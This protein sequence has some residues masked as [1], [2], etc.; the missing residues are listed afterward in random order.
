MAQR[1]DATKYEQA[2]DHQKE[3]GRKLIEELSLSGRES[4]FDLGCG[5]GGLTAQPAALVP[6]GGLTSQASCRLWNTW[7]FGDKGR[8]RSSV[9]ERMIASTRQANG[10]C[11]ETFHRINVFAKEGVK[12]GVKVNQRGEAR[13]VSA[14]RCY[15]RWPRRSKTRR[16]GQRAKRRPTVRFWDW[17]CLAIC[18]F[19]RARLPKKTPAG[20]IGHRGQHT[21]R[22]RPNPAGARVDVE[23]ANNKSLTR[24]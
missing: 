23:K 24:P 8:F 2:S 1:F 6:R 9:I 11:F 5:D 19:Q 12:G 4:I 22:E 20:A 15:R 10:S 3:W 7:V 13:R 16:P 14:T 21:P 17:L 18:G